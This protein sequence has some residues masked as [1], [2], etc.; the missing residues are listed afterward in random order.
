MK[1]C[2]NK[3]RMRILS[4]SDSENERMSILSASQSVMGKIE[5]AVDGAQWIK[6]KAGGSRGSTLVRMIFKDIEEP[7]LVTLRE[8]LYRV[9]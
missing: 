9:V 6:L 7:T 4:S 3:K 5:I 2:R 1:V 8:I